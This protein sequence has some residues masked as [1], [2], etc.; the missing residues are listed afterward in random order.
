LPFYSFIDNVRRKL[1]NRISSCILM[2]GS[3]VFGKVNKIVKFS[4][5]ANMVKIII[6]I[7]NCSNFH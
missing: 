2:R 7:P 6:S 5:I 3:G 4:K 1:N